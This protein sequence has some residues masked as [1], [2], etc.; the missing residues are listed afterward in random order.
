VLDA[1]APER[2]HEGDDIA[3]QAQ[4]GAGEGPAGIAEAVMRLT[5]DPSG[6]APRDDV[7]I[8]VA[9]VIG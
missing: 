2:I 6:R 1:H 7:A 5:D 8:L 3:R 4:R 9:Q